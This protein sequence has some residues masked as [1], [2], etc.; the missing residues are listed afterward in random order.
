MFINNDNLTKNII[1]NQQ[2]AIIWLKYLNILKNLKTY[3][4]SN[5][6]LH[7]TYKW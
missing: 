2:I 1:P 3:I 6:I 5:I 7:N 4:I